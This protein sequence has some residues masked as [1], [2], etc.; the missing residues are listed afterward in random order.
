MTRGSLAFHSFTVVLHIKWP[1]TTPYFLLLT[2]LHLS[3]GN[4]NVKLKVYTHPHT[5]RHKASENN[6]HATMT[7]SIMK[8]TQPDKLRLGRQDSLVSARQPW[9]GSAQSNCLS[10]WRCLKGG[11]SLYFWTERHAITQGKLHRQ[12]GWNTTEKTQMTVREEKK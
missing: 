6:K 8:Q 5:D 12:T 2:F 1:E 9:S 10:N 11:S 7:I 4:P 3:T